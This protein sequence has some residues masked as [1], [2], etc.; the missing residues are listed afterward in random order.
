MHGDRVDHRRVRWVRLDSEGAL[1]LGALVSNGGTVRGVQHKLCAVPLRDR[2]EDPDRSGD[3]TS[4]CGG[5]VLIGAVTLTSDTAGV[6]IQRADAL[7]VIAVQKDSGGITVINNTVLGALNVTQNTGTVVDRPNT[8][9]G[10]A[11]LQ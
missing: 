9:Y 2:G 3:G 8:V 1:V 11:E 10:N 7:G 5:S 6:S 4:S